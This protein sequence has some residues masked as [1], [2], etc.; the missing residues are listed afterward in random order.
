MRKMLNTL[1]L[2]NPE[3]YLRK[4]DDALCVRLGE[5]TVM[6]I[7]FHLLEGVVLFGHVGCSTSI[8]AA[9]AEAGVSVA[10]LDERGRFKARVE[11]PVSGNVLLRRRQYQCAG[12]SDECATLA[13][14]FVLAK[15]HNARVVLQHYRRDYPEL[16]GKGLDAAAEALQV[17]KGAV[18]A[19]GSLDELRGVEGDAAHAYFGIFDLL[20]RSEDESLRFHGRSRRPPKDPVNATLS[21]MYTMLARELAGACETVGLDPQMGFLHACRPGR[22]SLALDLLEELRAPIVDRFVLTLFNRGQLGASDFE[23]E[24]EGYR[25]SNR[26]LKKVLELW[27]EKKREQLMHP[28]LKERVPLGLVP[29]LQAQLCA[30]YLRGDLSDYPACLWR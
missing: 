17:S 8:L 1:Y 18:G 9:C 10:L 16:G 22:A 7:P 30:R 21:F 14:R 24:G 11:G 13:K 2:T 5:K 23:Q 25:F 12:D 6:S 3:A 28:F 26:A 15:I 29:F 19:A 20:I 4:K 27:Q